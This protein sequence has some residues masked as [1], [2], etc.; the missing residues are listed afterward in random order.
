MTVSSLQLE[1]WEPEYK[2]IYLSKIVFNGEFGCKSEN[3]NRL[4]LFLDGSNVFFLG[5]PQAGKGDWNLQVLDVEKNAQVPWKPSAEDKEEYRKKSEE[6]KKVLKKGGPLPQFVVDCGD[7]PV[8]RDQRVLFKLQSQEILCAFWFN[9]WFIKDN[10]CE[11]I[12]RR[13]N[14]DSLASINF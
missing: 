2:T 6:Q 11:G 4:V 3:A 1:K 8:I 7:I 12:P 13:C 5:V 14:I 9:T 10:V